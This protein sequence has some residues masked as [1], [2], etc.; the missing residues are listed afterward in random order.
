MSQIYHSY[1]R[2]LF[3]IAFLLMASF[4]GFAGNYTSNVATGDWNSASTWSPATGTP[5]SG[6]GVVITAGHVVTHTGI[7]TWSSNQISISGKLI[8]NGN[9]LL[10]G[11]ANL[12][13]QT[14]SELVVN[15][16]FIVENYSFSVA[17]NSKLTVSGK[18]EIQNGDFSILSSATVDIGGLLYVKNSLNL[19]A[20][21]SVG[22]Y[23]TVDNALN[24]NSGS[25]LKVVGNVTIANSFNNNSLADFDGNLTLASGQLN[26]NAGGT[27]AIDGNLS[28][29]NQVGVGGTLLVGG[30]YINT[31]GPSY[32]TSGNFYVLGT[33]SCISNPETCSNIKSEAE[34][35]S[36]GS[37]A[38][39]YLESDSSG[40][41]DHLANKGEE[42]GPIAVCPSATSNFSVLAVDDGNLAANIFEWAVYGGTITGADNTETVSGHAASVKTI[43]GGVI[44]GKSSISVAWEATTFDD[45][46]VAVRQTSAEGCSDGLWSVFHINIQKVVAPTGSAAQSFCASSNP[47]VADLAATGTS[48]QWFS[49][50]SGGTVL[51]AGTPLVTG[52][53]YASQTI[54][55]CASADRLAVA[56][57]I[58]ELAI[59][60][61]LPA[62]ICQWSLYPVTASAS[63][64][65]AP[66]TY[67]W[68]DTAGGPFFAGSVSSVSGNFVNVT[69]Y[70]IAAGTYTNNFKLTVTDANGCTRI[71]FYSLVV[72]PL[73]N[74]NWISS[75]TSVCT[76][77]TGVVYSVENLANTTYAWNVTGGV[78][79]SGAGTSSITVDWG[80][81]AGTGD[82]K[83]I[84]ET[85]LGCTTTISQSVSIRSILGITLGSISSVCPG[86]TSV[87]LSYSATSGSPNQYSID[88][89]GVANAAGLDDVTN[90]S[91]PAA[92]GTI[93]I[94]LPV[95][96]PSG[97]Y[98]GSLTLKN[99]TIS[100]VCS[101]TYL[102]TITI[103]DSEAPV[104]TGCPG[105][106]TQNVDAGVCSALV[107][108]SIPTASDNCGG[109]PVI[110]RTN[111]SG[112]TFVSETQATVSVGTSTITYTATD[113]AGNWAECSFT[114]TVTDN[115]APTISCPANVTVS[116][117]ANIPTQLSQ[118][119]LETN[120][121]VAD[122]CQIKTGS[123]V[124]TDVYSGSCHTGQ[125]LTIQRT[126]QISDN[127]TPANT[128]SCTQ[129]I[130]VNDV[131]IEIT[132]L[133][134][135]GCANNSASITS[136]VAGFSS[137]IYQ[138]EKSTDGGS[139]WN[140]VGTNS[141]SLAVSSP[142][143][144]DKYRLKVST[145]AANQECY[146]NILTVVADTFKPSFP[147][148]ASKY[149]GGVVVCDK[150]GATVIADL[151]S[152]ID[153]V[154]NCTLHAGLRTTYTITPASGPIVSGTN[155]NISVL[156]NYPFPLGT[157]TVVM[158]I[159][160]ETGNRS[161]ELTFEV[162]IGG[163][164]TL[165]DISTDGIP[166][167]NGSGYKPHQSSTHTYTVD[168]GTADPDFTYTWT[169]LDNAN[170]V[171]SPGSA[172]TYTI[173]AT[174]PAAVVISWGASIPLAANDYKV[175]VR[176]TSNTNTCFIEKELAVT[177]LENEFNAEVVEQGE[178]CQTGEAGTT[179]IVEWKI[180][181]SKGADDWR[182]DYEISDGVTV[183]A[184]GFEVPVSGDTKSIFFNVSN[185][186]GVDKTYTFKI[187]NVFDEFD[188]PETDL[189]DNEDSVTLW[190]IPETS[191]I[192]TD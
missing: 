157:S 135:S 65:T 27:L 62:T 80:S 192:S 137:P 14:G 162:K 57:T 164:F 58:A 172:N 40:W 160:D 6:D 130:T 145:G 103:A 95:N 21:L 133:D 123:L 71:K 42:A 106:I 102:V 53:Y 66:Y 115:I 37:P 127:A 186:A 85:A 188:T 24:N 64:G 35:I 182:F 83:V 177:V 141:S 69:T 86:T 105:N 84:A 155:A 44:D 92:P 111:S 129:I 98:N 63:G 156:N 60:D 70:G 88:F 13:L 149:T 75:T 7:L 109:T 108:W 110:V 45:A 119:Y 87:L 99:F 166:A 12:Y 54:G 151:I 101:E 169:V 51:A 29:N 121:L 138:W 78:I 122:N 153:A 16:D 97:T 116:G 48:I 144:N 72:N 165:S 120:N 167:T 143:I 55:G 9:L 38:A 39:T 136:V 59:S 47:T 134:L 10:N 28:M 20:S 159:V 52:N 126:Y 49:A 68:E 26:A 18:T 146:S 171:L 61:D 112:V 23:L 33:K 25:F 34:W 180:E 181:K 43:T 90:A 142:V 178:Q 91:L 147:V 163:Q 114:V 118:A 176:K 124:V 74:P 73:V 15:G 77:Q 11:S 131:S 107:S 187:L 2:P 36:A 175:R 148:T 89:D 41:E 46:Y 179:T 191:P 150:T 56:V 76:S 50:A 139:N 32:S 174:N 113:A 158:D 170:T 5:L 132:S 117:F 190:G 67:L 93:T 189:D 31:G 17:I 94:S 184:S 19:N 161:A 168:G 79:A 4:A 96:L 100:P 152:N 128:A 185:Q 125:P 22:Q 104:F 1:C 140:I 82:V 183:V 81:T 154:D 3:F 173:N 30:N 8:V